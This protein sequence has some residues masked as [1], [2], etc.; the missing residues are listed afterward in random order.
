[1]MSE[2][3]KYR[4]LANDTVQEVHATKCSSNEWEDIFSMQVHLSGDTNMREDIAEAHLP[5]CKLDVIG[6]GAKIL[7]A[8]QT[9]T[10]TSKRFM[11]IS[12]VPFGATRAMGEGSAVVDAPSKRVFDITRA[13]SPTTLLVRNVILQAGV[14]VDGELYLVN[15]ASQP[16]VKL[17]GVGIIG[18]I[19]GIVDVLFRSVDTKPI[20]SDL[21]FLGGVAKAHEG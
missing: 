3:T 13:S 2:R 17:A 8:M 5:Q 18:V 4:C 11:K 7:Q 14:G 6:M 21:E 20:T 1:M 10:K 12:I 9:L 16:L 19:L 15:R